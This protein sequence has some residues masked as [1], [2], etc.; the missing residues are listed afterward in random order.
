VSG[1][2]EG[3]RRTTSRWFECFFE[4]PLHAA[5][6]TKWSSLRML[7]N[8]LFLCESSTIVLD[9]PFSNPQ[10][11]MF[12]SSSVEGQA[13]GS[14]DCYLFFMLA[15]SNAVHY[16]DIRFRNCTHSLNFVYWYIW[17][18]LCFLRTFLC[19]RFIR[20]DTLSAEY[21]SQ[22]QKEE[23]LTVGS[24]DEQFKKGNTWLTE[25]QLKTVEK[26]KRT[27]H[28]FYCWKCN[29]VSFLTYINILMYPRDGHICTNIGI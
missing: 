5:P 4:G 21:T 1:G 16:T 23:I 11:K 26:N 6:K 24:N 3:R 14:N 12:R 19:T 9:T 7:C 29:G 13:S 18:F 27:K 10:W 28:L 22:E 20:Y 25:Q 8:V 15:S 17:Q 2:S